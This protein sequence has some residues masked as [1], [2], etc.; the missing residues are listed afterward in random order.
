MHTPTR[1]HV[2]TVTAQTVPPE[3]QNVLTRS[4]CGRQ[5]ASPPHAC[6]QRQDTPVMV[7]ATHIILH[8]SQNI[9]AVIHGCTNKLV[10]QCV[11]NP[12]RD[13]SLN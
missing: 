9:Q 4:L 5:Q 11:Q 8:V 2:V 10:G 7:V 1:E 12:Q 13:L 6:A 3:R